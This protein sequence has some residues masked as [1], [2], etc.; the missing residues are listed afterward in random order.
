LIFFAD[1]SAIAK[2]YVPEVGSSWVLSW[3]LPSSSHMIL[4]SDLTQVEVFSVLARR[5]REKSISAASRQTLEANF[6]LHIELEYLSVPID[7]D[8]IRTARELT[9]RH[10]L[11]ALDSIQLGS[12]ITA[13]DSL[14][15]SVTFISSDNILLAAAAAE[16]FA[17]DNPLNH[18]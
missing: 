7:A 3:V 15:D 4:V 18:P 12:A 2:R 1:T 5:E 14:Q 16:G 9:H 6:L 17:V 10:P 11:R 13:R 8:V